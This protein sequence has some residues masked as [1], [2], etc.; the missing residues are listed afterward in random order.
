ME[1]H[2]VLELQK[3]GAIGI[4]NEAFKIPYKSSRFIFLTFLTSL[5]VMFTMVLHEIILKRSI[6]ETNS[7]LTS[8]PPPS[9]QYESITIFTAIANGSAPIH[10]NTYNI[11]TFASY[12]SEIETII[13][14][15]QNMS[16]RFFQLAFL[17]LVPLHLLDLV[18]TIVTVQTTST[19][20]AETPIKVR[21][22]LHTVTAET[23]FVGPLITSLYV[24]FLNSFVLFGLIWAVTNSFFSPFGNLV[25]FMY[26]VGSIGL[27][28]KWVEWT[29]VW[30]VS[31][32]FSVLDGKHWLDA[33][34]ASGYI[35]RG[36][37]TR[38]FQL[39][40]LFFVWRIF[41]RL[42][43]HYVVGHETW[44]GLVLSSFLSCV[45]NVMKWV[46]CTVYFYDCKN[47]AFEKKVDTEEG[48]LLK[49]ADTGSTECNDE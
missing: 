41:L 31:T 4:L 46:V 10:N 14:L 27:T 39:M 45:G 36:N 24:L 12:N 7:L 3:L 20:Y 47:R 19:I 5:P 43:C 22:M 25:M 13:M 34:R 16:P 29:A 37:R 49:N 6:V 8:P 9:Y 28:V 30:N 35:S 11:V 15:V 33:F 17:Y 23:R 18:N 42:L 26:G 1:N 48:V 2:Q 32:I 38:G 21:E 44:S 40:L